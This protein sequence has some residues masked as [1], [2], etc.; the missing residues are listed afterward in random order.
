MVLLPLRAAQCQP[1]VLLPLRASATGQSALP[2]ARKDSAD[3]TWQGQCG[4]AYFS[5]LSLSCARQ[6]RCPCSHK[7]SNRSQS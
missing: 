6:E 1:V 3:V 7:R 5:P 2:L 4:L